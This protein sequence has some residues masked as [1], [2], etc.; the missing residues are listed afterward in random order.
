MIVRRFFEW[1][2]TAGAEEKA[3][4]ASALARAFL[5]SDLDD[6]NQRAAEAVLTGLVEDPSPLVRRAL[7]EA[8]ASAADAPHHCV[9]VLANDQ[10]DIASIVLSR[11]PVLTDGELIDCA[12]VEIGRAH[13]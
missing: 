4:G 5:Y 12:T 10:S 6:D 9:A 13:V 2:K 7:A 11:S 3:E 8:F 1:A